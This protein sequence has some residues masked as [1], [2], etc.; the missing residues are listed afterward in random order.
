MT[1]R[2][3][4]YWTHCQEALAALHSVSSD[5]E[6]AQAKIA[7]ELD[8]YSIKLAAA[9]PSP[10][11]AKVVAR[12]IVDDVLSFIGRERLIAFHPAYGQ[13]GLLDKVHDAA[14]VHLLLRPIEPTG[15]RHLTPM[16]ASTRFRK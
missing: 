7:R 12:S 6:A 14:A 10:P 16:K 2:A 11:K 1:K 8:A 5:E 13:G 4:R 9:H 15:P 3:G